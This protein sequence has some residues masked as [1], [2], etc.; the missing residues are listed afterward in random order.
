M[1]TE[2]KTRSSYVTLFELE[3][4]LRA[5]GENKIILRK[6]SITAAAGGETE[7][8]SVIAHATMATEARQVERGEEGVA[9]EAHRAA[10]VGDGAEV[11]VWPDTR[12]PGSRRH[13]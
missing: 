13:S 6:R 3:I 8:P 11:G 10:A 4:R 5:Y 1:A 2:A 9:N 12:G 7:T